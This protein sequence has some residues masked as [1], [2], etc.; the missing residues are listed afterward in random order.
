MNEVRASGVS[1]NP[2]Y[3]GN[4]LHAGLS[5]DLQLDRGA[6]PAKVPQACSEPFDVRRH[7]AVL[8]LEDMQNAAPR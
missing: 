4:V 8:R 2:A 3:G 1:N 5:A 6:A 7:A